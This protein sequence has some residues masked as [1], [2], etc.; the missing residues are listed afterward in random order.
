MNHRVFMRQLSRRIRERLTGMWNFSSLEKK[1]ALAVSL[2]VVCIVGL[3]SLASFYLT[4]SHYEAMLYQSMSTSSSLVTYL[5]SSHLDDAVQLSDA[6]RSDAVIQHHLDLI[7]QGKDYRRSNSYDNI[8]TS[9]LNY[10]LQYKKPYLTYSAI[11]NPRFVT[12]TYDYRYNRFSEEMLQEMQ[13]EAARALGAPVWFS[14][15]AEDGY[16]Y[17]IRQIR[18]IEYLDLYDLGTVAI[19][20]DMEE[21]LTEITRESQGYPNIFWIFSQDGRTIY[22]S[23]ELQGTSLDQIPNLDGQYG[24]ISLGDHQYFAMQGQLKDLDWN[25]YQLVPYDTTAAAQTTLLRTY[26]IVVFLGLAFT[27]FFIHLSIRRAV[28]GIQVLCRKMNAFRGD[29]AQAVHVPYDYSR[30]KDEIGQLHLYFDN[31]A[32]EIETLINSDY[33]LKLDMKNMQLG[34]LRA[35]INPHF[36]YN[37][38]DSI[39]WRAKASGNEEICTMVESLGLLLRS[40]LSQKHSL[41]PFREELD[42]V[43]RYLS[44]QQIRYEDRLSCRF[45]LDDGLEDVLVPPLSIQPLVENSIKYGLEEF[46]DTC[47]IIISAARGPEDILVVEVRNNGS[48]FEEGLLEKLQQSKEQASGTG[49]GL[50]NIHQRIQLLFGAEYGLTLYNQD[51]FAVASIRIPITCQGGLAY[52]ETDHRR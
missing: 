26:V 43:N 52:A 45:Q 2:I 40:S 33:K 28:S 14:R 15:Y 38:L 4:K 44:I 25:Y 5:L 13:A 50:L 10:Y 48:F 36:L 9:Q 21:L 24:L 47:S 11:A 8:Y 42:L 16:L 35:Q 46:P 32:Q 3:F 23:S 34:A 7:Y 27:V 18:K 29:N 37:T 1:L 12:Y 31:M 19:A 17:L 51:G 6:I 49:I 39:Y 20:I 30:R 41:V 22:A